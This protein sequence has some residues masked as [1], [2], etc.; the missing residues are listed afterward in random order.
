MFLFGETYK[1]KYSDSIP[2]ANNFY[3]SHSGYYDELTEAAS[4]LYL[5]TN[6]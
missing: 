5:A 1:G 2:D 4:I 6:D 3:K